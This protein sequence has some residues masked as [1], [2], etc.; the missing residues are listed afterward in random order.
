MTDKPF[1]CNTPLLKHNQWLF[2]MGSREN[3]EIF[4][5]GDALREGSIARRIRL[6][7]IETCTGSAKRAARTVSPGE[8]VWRGLKLLAGLLFG[9]GR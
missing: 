1:S 9:F 3:A 8:F 5:R 4:L 7:R 6:A 2:R